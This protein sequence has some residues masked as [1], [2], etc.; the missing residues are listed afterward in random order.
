MGRNACENQQLAIG[1]LAKHCKPYRRITRTNAN[2]ASRDISGIDKK[3]FDHE[4]REAKQKKLG[5]R[6]SG[7]FGEKEMAQKT[8]SSLRVHPC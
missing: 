5:N 3:T 8:C 1:G 6:M 4:G 7:K 2:H